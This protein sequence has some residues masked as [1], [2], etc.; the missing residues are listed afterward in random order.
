MIPAFIWLPVTYVVEAETFSKYLS[1]GENTVALLSKPHKF[2][3]N[4]FTGGGAEDAEADWE[5]ERKPSSPSRCPM[6]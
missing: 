6:S 4:K 3:L 5:E 1:L 2:G